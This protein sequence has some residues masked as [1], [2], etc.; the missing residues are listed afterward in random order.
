VATSAFVYW[1]WRDLSPR[2]EL[3]RVPRCGGTV[4]LVDGDVGSIRVMSAF[5]DVVYFALWGDPAN[6]YEPRPRIF[7]LPDDGPATTYGAKKEA[8]ALSPT[9]SWLYWVGS[10]HEPNSRG[11]Y[12]TDLSAPDE[13]TRFLDADAWNGIAADD[14]HMF[15]GGKGG[16][17][18]GAIDD[19]TAGF[20]IV[21]PLV[22]TAAVAL[23][24]DWLVG[25]DVEPVSGTQELYLSRKDGTERQLVITAD[26]VPHLVT[27]AEHIYIRANGFFDAEMP[28]DL[29]IYRF[30]LPDGQAEVV[31]TA[32]LDGEFDIAD[33]WLYAYSLKEGVIR[34]P[35]P[36]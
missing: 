13:S 29:D 17:R 1:G 35:L 30:A 4:E 5:E 15:W 3:Y 31:L 22:T 20:E 14:Q 26:L 10:N 12:R 27:D 24:D 18:R 28:P 16:V 34:V 36:N 19:A 7:R 9:A 32:P 2:W 11:A 25:F 33:G 8:L 6:N 21:M 23:L